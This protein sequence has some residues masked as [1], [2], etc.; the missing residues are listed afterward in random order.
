MRKI[1]LFAGVITGRERV[2]NRGQGLVA[3]LEGLLESQPNAR[4]G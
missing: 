2:L 3:D 1:C 4:L